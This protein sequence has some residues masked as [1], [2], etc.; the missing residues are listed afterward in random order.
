[1]LWALSSSTLMPNSSSSPITISTV[2]R[3]SA[4]S[5]ANFDSPE[6]VVS[7]DNASCFFTILHTLSTV[8]GL[9]AQ[10]ILRRAGTGLS[11]KE[12]KLFPPLEREIAFR[13][14]IL[15]APKVGRGRMETYEPAVAAIGEMLAIR[16]RKLSKRNEERLG[17]FIYGKGKAVGL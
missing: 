7:S 4:P 16:R 9:A 13:L 17:A 6:T 14:E 8:S 12:R 15:V 10:E 11:P 1:M 2:S 5:C 3:E